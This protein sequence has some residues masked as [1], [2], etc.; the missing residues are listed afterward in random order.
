M[1]KRGVALSLGSR[2]FVTPCLTRPEIPP[3]PIPVTRLQDTQTMACFTAVNIQLTPS[4]ES[5]RSS[6]ALQ[7][8]LAEEHND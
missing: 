7:R 3:D 2:S 6:A 1:N 4:A 5:H 8:V